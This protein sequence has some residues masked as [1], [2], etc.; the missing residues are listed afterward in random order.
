[1][2]QNFSKRPG[3]SRAFGRV[4]GS[5]A[6]TRGAAEAPETPANSASNAVADFSQGAFRAACAREIANLGFRTAAKMLPRS[7]ETTR[8][9]LGKQDRA[10]VDDSFV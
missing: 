7:D 5:F 10:V 8:P 3:S 1:M 4:R 2:F 9:Q 6:S